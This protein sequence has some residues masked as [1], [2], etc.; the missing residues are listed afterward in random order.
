MRKERGLRVHISVDVH[1]HSQ[2]GLAQ[3]FK[4]S[5]EANNVVQVVKPYSLHIKGMLGL[6]PDTSCS[7]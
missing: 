6:I 4:T 7:S 3:H 2:N 1:G 5:V